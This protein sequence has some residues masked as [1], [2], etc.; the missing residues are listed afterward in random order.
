MSIADHSPFDTII[1][2]AGAAGLMCA[3]TAG[4]RGRRV[5]LLE[6]SNKVGKKI[7]MSGG[8]RCNFTNLH[9]SPERFLSANPHF[10]KSALSRYTQWDFIELVKRHRIAYFQ[11]ETVN[12]LSGQLFCEQSSKQIVAMLLQECAD[13]G[14]EI[15]T[16]CET[17]AVT[18]SGDFHAATSHG[19]FSAQT[20]V[21]AT[22]G[23][24]IPSLG[25]SGLGYQLAEQFGLRLLP[26]A[27][28]LVP[29]TIT[30]ALKE[31][32]NTLSGVACEVVVS[33]PRASFREDL[34]FTHR[35]LSGPAVL[36]ISSYWQPGE[37]VCV[38]LLPGENA[39][40]RLL[41]WKHEHPR[42]LLRTQLGS[43]LPRQLVLEVER[44]FWP[45]NSEKLL[46]DWPDRELEKLAV[47]LQAWELKPAGTEGYRT[48][49][50]TLG[51]V[52]TRD[53]SSKT[54]ESST[55]GLFFIGEVV[56]VTGHLGGF[57][58][59]WAWASGHATGLAV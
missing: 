47:R 23:L 30:G 26:T 12:G 56:D 54:M 3:L 39:R 7:L 38:D 15:R 53:L 22:G 1:M 8:G 21:I 16:G 20:L 41:A 34:L 13:V 6:R 45:G 32:C 17:S 10:C 42:A 29:L 44:L 35:G 33:N 2:G 36:Q 31:T 51:G 46:A 57:N 48:A 28:G 25:G 27:A 43:V 49:E 50:V 5:L 24:S 11:K 9:V 18:H 58:F 14:V 59:Q 40:A 52:D 19:S 55:P 4:Q 37:T